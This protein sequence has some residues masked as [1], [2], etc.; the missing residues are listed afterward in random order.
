MNARRLTHA[1]LLILALLASQSAYAIHTHHDEAVGGEERCELC[2]Y[3][4]KFGSFQPVIAVGATVPRAERISERSRQLIYR[5]PSV[6]YRNPRA[7][8]R[9]LDRQHPFMIL[10]CPLSGRG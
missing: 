1:L 8:P 3:G 9:A 2:L 6:W 4:A 10:P 7:P 5:P